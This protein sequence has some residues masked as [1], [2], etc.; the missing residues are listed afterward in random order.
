MLFDRQEWGVHPPGMPLSL[1]PDKYTLMRTVTRQWHCRRNLGQLNCS[2]GCKQRLKP[3]SPAFPPKHQVQPVKN[4]TVQLL[5]T[6]LY[7]WASGQLSLENQH[8]Q[9]LCLGSSWKWQCCSSSLVH[10][11]LIHDSHP[12]SS[13]TL[14]KSLPCTLIPKGRKKAEGRGWI[15]NHLSINRIGY[16]FLSEVWY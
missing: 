5:R 1:H 8:F 15:L 4:P 10:W 16:A 7:L 2:V 11:Y 9:M 12:T 14:F 3:A 6:G 13:P